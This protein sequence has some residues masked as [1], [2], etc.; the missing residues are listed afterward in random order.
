[1]KK[2]DKFSKKN[3]QYKY[4]FTCICYKGIC[5]H[6]H[7][8]ILIGIVDTNILY[9]YACA[10]GVI[11]NFTFYHLNYICFISDVF[12]YVPLFFNKTAPLKE[13]ILI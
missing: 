1:M 9:T 12:N 8:Y 4:K 3:I 2:L 11:F 5:D 6:Q 10:C 13:F 7:L